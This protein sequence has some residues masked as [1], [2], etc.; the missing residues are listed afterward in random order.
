MKRKRY[1]DKF[2]A[3]AVV[4]LEAAGYPEQK[5]ALSH[6]ADHLRVP[7]MTLSRWFKQ[8]NNPPPNELV[9]EKRTDF[10]ANLKAL[11]WKLSD[12][13]PSKIEDANLQQV[14][15]VLGIVVDKA[16]LLEGKATERVDHTGLTRDERLTRIGELLTGRGTGGTAGTPRSTDD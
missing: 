6:V 14:G 7:A 4:M 10:L 15:T 3:S 8:S 9:T 13:I 5:G 1:D 2:R 16:Q 11:A 12:A